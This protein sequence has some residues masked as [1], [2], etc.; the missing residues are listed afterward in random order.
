MKYTAAIL[1]PALLGVGCAEQPEKRVYAEIV[2]EAPPPV[3]RVM[4]EAHRDMRD[5]P[6]PPVSRP[7]GGS[8][9]VWNTPAGWRQEPGTGMRL[10]TLWI[11]DGE[12]TLIVLSGDVGGLPANI[13]RWMDQ[14]QL[15]PLSPAHMQSYIDS[16]ERFETAT[17]LSGLLLDF[18]MFVEEPTA[19]STLGGIIQRGSETMFV[20]LTGSKSLLARERDNFIALC[21]SIQ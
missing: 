4:E 13:A 5:L 12:C 2:V 1:V 9:F 7:Y 18:D 14:V 3:E 21:R 20:K 10:A 6:L 17:G 11:E 16:L 8:E 19:L 15:R